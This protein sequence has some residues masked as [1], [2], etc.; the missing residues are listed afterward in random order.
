MLIE[1]FGGLGIYDTERPHSYVNT[2]S[3]RTRLQTGKP[4]RYHRV[5]NLFNA[6]SCF[7]DDVIIAR[8]FVIVKNKNY[9]CTHLAGYFGI[10]KVAN[11]YKELKVN[12]LFIKLS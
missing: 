6:T 11:A 4:D 10:F 8:Y 9:L 3:D 7:I 12:N 5:Y 2:K 1:G